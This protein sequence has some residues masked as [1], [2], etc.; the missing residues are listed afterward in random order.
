MPCHNYSTTEEYISP[1]MF[2]DS[3]CANDR[4]SFTSCSS[5]LHS[6][7]GDEAS[8]SPDR[9]LATCLTVLSILRRIGSHRGTLD[10]EAL[11]LGGDIHNLRTE[12]GT[13]FEGN[14]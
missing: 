12:L 8:R 2:R 9:K 6:L 5:A 4:H 11:L 10:V 7:K 13:M 14:R 1:L 3:C